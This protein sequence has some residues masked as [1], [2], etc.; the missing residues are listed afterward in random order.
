MY[1][2]IPS[3][4]KPTTLTVRPTSGGGG[5]QPFRRTTF[6]QFAMLEEAQW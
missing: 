5:L 4:E 3:L 6:S 1:V 2:N